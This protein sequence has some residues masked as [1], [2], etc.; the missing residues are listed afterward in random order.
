MFLLLFFQLLSTFFD[1]KAMAII[2]SHECICLDL[3]G[4]AVILSASGHKYIEFI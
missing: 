4:A 1:T 3:V 2:T